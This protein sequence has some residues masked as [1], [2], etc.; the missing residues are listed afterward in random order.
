MR[1]RRAFRPS[2]ESMPRRDVPSG[3]VILDP[4]APIMVPTQPRP[5]YLL[6]TDPYHITSPFPPE[7]PYVGPDAPSPT[8]PT[9]TLPC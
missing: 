1:T 5:N 2:L 6:P 3:V 7:D 9:G 4:L 8:S